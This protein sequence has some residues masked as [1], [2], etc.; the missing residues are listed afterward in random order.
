VRDFG[1]GTVNAMVDSFAAQTP[2][3]QVLKKHLA[4]TPKDFDDKLNAYLNAKWGASAGRLK[5]FREALKRA[6]GAM[7]SKDW[8]AAEAGAKQ[9]KAAFPEHVASYEA[10]GKIYTEKK[11]TT[12][13]RI[14][15]RE[16]ARRGGR[17]VWALKELA[18]VEEAG[19]DTKAAA[20]A[21]QRLIYV[22]PVGDEELHKKLGEYYL[23]LAQPE[24]AMASFWAQL[25]SKPVDPAGAYYNLARSYVALSR[26]ADAQDALLQ[27]LELAPGFKPAQK[28]LLEL[29]SRSQK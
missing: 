14:E 1:Q 23:T 3:E 8:A 22:A 29:E 19:G 16:Y 26:R 13:A 21:L 7:G 10:L 9:A 17:A 12:A 28:L 11:D 2:L 20:A 5:E 18:K 27:A 4:L 24:R 25:A 15:L 6:Q